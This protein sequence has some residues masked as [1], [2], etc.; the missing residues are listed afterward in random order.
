MNWKELIYMVLDEIK[1]ESDDFSF[2]PDHI[3]FQLNNYRAFL[4][5]QKYGDIRRSIPESNY[6]VISL[7]LIRYPD[8]YRPCSPTYLRSTI[9]VPNIIKIGNP[10]VYGDNFYTDSISFIPRERMRYIGHNKY[11][12]N[13]IYCSLSPDKYLTLI[14]S[15]PQFIYLEKVLLS[16]VFEDALASADM[17]DNTGETYCDPID[18]DFPM[19]QSLVPP[20]IELVVKELTGAMYRPED[21]SNNA[22]DDLTNN[23]GT[24]TQSR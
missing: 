5:R 7:D 18:R 4:L 8:E 9:K 17:E 22:K 13:H 3:A 24:N 14:S 16:A 10:K 6:Q 1:G 11:L 21:N 19:E 2:T 12:Q 23:V 15:N 20:L